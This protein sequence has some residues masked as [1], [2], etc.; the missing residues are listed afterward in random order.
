MR[1]ASRKPL[2]VTRSVGSPLRSSSAL[3]ATVVP[4]LT[5]STACGVTGSPAFSPSR[6]RMPAMA[7]SL[8]CSGFSDSSLCVTSDPSGRFATMSV[9]VPPRSIQNCQRWPRVM[10][11]FCCKC[12]DLSLQIGHEH[13][14]GGMGDAQRQ[15]AFLGHPLRRDAAGPENGDFVILDADC[16]P[17]VRLGEFGDANFPRIADVHGHPMGDVESAGNLHHLGHIAALDGAH[18]HDHVALEEAGRLAR[19]TGAVHRDIA[20]LLHVAQGYAR[21]SHGCL[22]RETAADEKG[23]EVPLPE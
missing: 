23:H 3:V 22:E 9:K 5:H 16:V 21:L 17:V 2:V 4:I 12:M 13:L 19:N 1:K 15:A 14:A 20:A 7:A 11:A 10:G 6:C 18:A 8:Y